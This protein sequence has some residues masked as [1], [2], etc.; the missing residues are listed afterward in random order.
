MIMDSY[1]PLMIPNI[2]EEDIEAVTD[3]LRSGMLVQGLKVEQLEKEIAEYLNVDFAIAVSNGTAALHMSLVALGV[4][5]G[6]EIIIPALSYIATANVV[7]LVGAKPVF[8]D[9]DL[10]TFN[11][12][13]TKIEA[14]I[15]DKTMAIMPVHEFGL[16]ADINEIIEIA[17]SHNLFV[18]EDAACA[19]G[20]TDN[21]K[22]AGSFGTVGSFSFH[23]RKAI[24]S[25]EGGVIVTNDASLAAKLRSLR[26]HGIELQN[27]E[28]EFVLPGFN[29]RMT[30]FQAALL[31]SQFKRFDEILSYKQELVE[32]YNQNI[33]NP[34]IV[35]PSIP[36]GKK[37]SWQTYHIVLDDSVNRNE[38]M[39]LLRKNNVGTN[40]GAQCIPNEQFYKRKYNLDCK[41]LFPNAIAAYK[42]G[43]AIPLY[44]KLSKEQIAYIS[45]ILNKID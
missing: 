9:I 25:G 43:L 40:Y 24:T 31:S 38:A 20:A 14:A 30:D 36:K 16:V 2:L 33:N 45:E 3:V 28:M 19:L 27:G 10:K 35:I 23:P 8:V 17:S 26:N 7:E 29:Y 42:Q 1:I 12:D 22:F 5:E 41:T 13:V 11:I 37:H 18:I 34:K 6:D 32:V 15:T 39:E 4:G 21:M 44:E